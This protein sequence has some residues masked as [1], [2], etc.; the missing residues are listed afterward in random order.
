MISSFASQT[1]KILKFYT[2][3]EGLYSTWSKITQWGKRSFVWVKH[4]HVTNQRV[5]LME[6]SGSYSHG[7]WM[8]IS[9]KPFSADT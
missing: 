4:H 6:M 7:F 9:R 2:E 1:F 8:T 5:T 3:K